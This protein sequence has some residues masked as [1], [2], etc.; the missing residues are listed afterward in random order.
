MSASLHPVPRAG[1]GGRARAE[2]GMR[3]FERSLPM[4]LM[5]ARERVMLEFRR[6]L[7]DHG[8][9]EQ[10]WRVV[11][12]LQDRREGYDLGELAERTYLLVASAS[13]IVT[14]LA[15]RGLV[16]RAPDPEDGRRV[17]ITLTAEGH[18]LFAAVAPRSEAVYARIEQTFGP[19][20]L[21]QLY[22]LLDDLAA[23][24]VE[25]G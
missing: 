19:D 13:R 1:D 3:A 21:A 25:H 18:E 16:A 14:N 6:V 23:I 9:S 4:A 7:H 2:P 10:Q 20:R 24:E 17:R 5:R 12:A 11:R 8:L 22:E 15:A